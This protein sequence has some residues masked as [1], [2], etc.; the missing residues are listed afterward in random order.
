MQTVIEADS[1]GECFITIP[2]EIL[3]SLGWEEGDVLDISV[4][5]DTIILRK[6]DDRTI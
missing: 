2:D 5:G 3:E 1:S 6:K 4:D